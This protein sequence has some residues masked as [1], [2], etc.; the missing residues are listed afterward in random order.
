MVTAKAD[1]R[2]IGFIF[3]LIPSPIL[4]VASVL[5][6]RG[7]A[8]GATEKDIIKKH[9]APFR[10]KDYKDDKHDDRDFYYKFGESVLSFRFEHGVL[11]A[12]ALN[13]DYLPY[14]EK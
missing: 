12:I 9:G 10:R 2:I 4:K 7:I 1:G 3:Y 14:L 13:S 6:D 11:K 8:A 5:T